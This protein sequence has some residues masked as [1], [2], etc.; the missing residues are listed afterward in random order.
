MKAFQLHKTPLLLLIAEA[1]PSYLQIHPEFIFF[2]WSRMIEFEK[3]I[4][5]K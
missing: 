5:G 4:V 3:K 2:K 1:S